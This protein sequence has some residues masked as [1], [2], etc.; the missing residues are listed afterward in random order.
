M[1]MSELPSQNAESNAPVRQRLRRRRKPTV[2]FDLTET[3]DPAFDRVIE[4]MLITLLAFC[5]IAIGGVQAW[6]EQVVILLAIAMALT[7]AIKLLVHREIRFV[8]SWTYLPTALFLLLVAGQLVPLPM[9]IV[10]M[11]SPHT[12]QLKSTLLAV[13]PDAA[14]HLRSS[15]ISFYPEATWHDLRLISA[16]A[17]VYIVVLNVVRQQRQLERILSAMTVIGTGIALIC[18]AHLAIGAD[19]I[20][21]TWGRLSSAWPVAPFINRNHF[22]QFMNLS[23]GAAL[24]L[25]L[26]RVDQLHRSQ[27]RDSVPQE[28]R[29]WQ[30]PAA[31]WLILAAIAVMLIGVCMS[32]SRG[33]ILSMLVA[34]AV[35]S[36][37]MRRHEASARGWLLAPAA[38]VALMV[39]VLFGFDMIAGRFEETGADNGGRWELV[40]DSLV[41]WKQFPVLGTGMGTFET[42]FPSV[43]SSQLVN[44]ATHAENEYI[45]TLMETGIVGLGLLVW[46]LVEMITRLLRCLKSAPSSMASAAPGFAFAITA[47]ALQSATDFGQHVPA[48]AIAVAVLFALLVNQS[49]ASGRTTAFVEPVPSRLR[50]AIRAAAAL[51]LLVCATGFF[52]QAND[53]RIAEAARFDARDV[54]SRLEARDW[55]GTDQEYFRLLKRAEAASNAR[56]DD[57][58]HRYR[59][60]FYRW[61]AISRVSDPQT[62]QLILTDLQIGWAER[63]VAE[64][65]SA[66]PLCPTYGPAYLLAGDIEQKILNK[67]QQGAAKI[68]T[69][70]ELSRADPLANFE[71]ARLDAGLQQLDRALDKFRHAADL[72]PAYLNDG[73]ES[74]AK[75][76]HRA[77]LA[78]ELAGENVPAVRRIVEI[79]TKS[80]NDA[81][82]ASAKTR[83]EELIR[84]HAANRNA[85]ADALV[86]AGELAL[87]RQEYDAAADFYKRALQ[88]NSTRADWRLALARA[89]GASGKTQ[90]ALTE[91]YTAQRLG[92]GGAQSLILELRLRP[93][94]TGK[95]P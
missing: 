36:L 89:L 77:D 72:V 10:Q 6:S 19:R 75:E 93:A 8:W 3:S 66:I 37:A 44:P 18:F 55:Q 59:L 52:F 40:K 39:V 24:A 71:A 65:T 16:I 4:A 74:L 60:N 33:A 31:F 48:N 9:A 94:T 21:G 64:L 82:L 80:Q 58:Q 38:L 1:S 61:K 34:G 62:G 41:A 47:V 49:E 81:A 42:F 12:A 73:V 76:H 28:Q 5:P 35:A 87:S 27:R 84:L 83:L 90:E 13:I 68:R 32:I 91:A 53:A 50:R 46:F 43:N 15:T 56:P 78:L 26:G 17:T 30:V 95:T 20:Y 70:Y 14:R 2:L 29:I 63:V 86:D 45:Q 22:G 79:L 67:G 57:A 25:L 51:L 92:S 85:P 88:I 54:E 69:S 23:L 7:L 11:L